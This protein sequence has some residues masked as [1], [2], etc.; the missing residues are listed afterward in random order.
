MTSANAA[1][2]GMRDRGLLREGMTADLAIFDEAS[3]VDRATYT[4]P[5][6][7]NE[8]IEYVVVAGHIVLE[9][10]RH[11]GAKPGRVLRRGGASLTSRDE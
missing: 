8:G 6:Q 1:K 5:F 9:R 11:T 3:V 2:L 7:Y 4:A 10:G